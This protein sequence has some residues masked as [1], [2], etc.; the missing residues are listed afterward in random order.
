L[1]DGCADA[2]TAGFAR[3]LGQLIQAPQQLR[4]KEQTSGM[5]SP[6]SPIITRPKLGY[7]A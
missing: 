6:I 5:A 2:G 3:L 4:L 1:A 7:R